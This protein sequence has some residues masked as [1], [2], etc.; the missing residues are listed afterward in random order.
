[1]TGAASRIMMVRRQNEIPCFRQGFHQENSLGAATRE[2]VRKQDDG[3]AVG[4]GRPRRFP[5]RHLPARNRDL[6]HGV[7][8]AANHRQELVQC[9]RSDDKN[10]CHH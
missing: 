9:Q 4:W 10:D 1:M 7:S 2:A 6:G 8:G 3:I 5:H